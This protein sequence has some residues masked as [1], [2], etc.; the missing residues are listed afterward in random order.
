MKS[1]FVLF[2]FIMFVIT[3]MYGQDQKPD[4]SRVRVTVD[5]RQS[6]GVLRRPELYNNN[7]LLRTP[8]E[9]VTQKIKKEIGMTKIMRCWVT[10]ND[11][12]DYETGRYTYDFKCGWDLNLWDTFY[13]YMGR[14]SDISE[15]IL[16]N[17]RGWEREVLD[18]KITMEQWRTAVKNGLKH[19]KEKFPRIRYIEV[20]NEFWGLGPASEADDQYYRFYKEFYRIVNEINEELK[21]AT[22]LLVGGPNVVSGDLETGKKRDNIRAFLKNFANDRNPSKKLDFISYHEYAVAKNPSV[23]INHEQLLDSWCRE[24]GLPEN[25]PIFIT[26]MGDN[27]R[28]RRN[29][30]IQDNQLLQASC[31]ATMFYYFNLQPDIQ[32]FQ[33]VIQHKTQDRKNQIF[34]NLRWSPYGMSLKMQARMARNQVQAIAPPPVEGK[35]VYC[36]ASEDDSKVTVLLWNYQW[37]NGSTTSMVD[38]EVQ[39]L[40]QNEGNGKIKIGEYLLDRKNNNIHTNYELLSKPDPEEEQ[41]KARKSKEM[42]Y[43]SSI[44]HRVVLEPNAMSLVEIVKVP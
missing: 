15:D 19:Y 37:E 17:V 27:S 9:A 34:D 12:W 16:F 6:K 29:T 11:F 22:P 31:L 4:T 40:F 21:P 32:A 13:G 2:I 14:F 26:E 5:C 18:G 36:L 23:L 41:L 1:C 3:D 7:S 8:S 10:I 20:L 30:L 44:N 42:D 25:Y 43:R 33:W 35:G 24:F 39:S 38:L 28:N